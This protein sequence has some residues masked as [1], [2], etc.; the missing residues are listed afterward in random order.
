VALKRGTNLVL[1]PGALAGGVQEAFSRN[2]PENADT[3]AHRAYD[4]RREAAA[5]G[6]T[7]FAAMLRKC[8]PPGCMR[9]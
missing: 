9:A 2:L 6:A 5:S 7:I 1:Q 8:H 4:R 3:T